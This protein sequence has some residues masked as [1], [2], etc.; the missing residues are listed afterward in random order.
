M[1]DKVPPLRIAQSGSGEMHATEIEFTLALYKFFDAGTVP[2]CPDGA[3][4]RLEATHECLRE[5]VELV[6][7]LWLRNGCV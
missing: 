1:R 2:L 6:V 5:W 4:R 7:D 3:S